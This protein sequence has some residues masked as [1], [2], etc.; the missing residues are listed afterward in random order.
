[1]KKLL[2]LLLSLTIVFSIAGCGKKNDKITDDKEQIKEEQLKDDVSS[3]ENKEEPKE[4]KKEEVIKTSTSD[5]SSETQNKKPDK[6]TTDSTVNNDKPVISQ[7]TG[8]KE[9]PTDKTPVENTNTKKFIENLKKSANLRW[10]ICVEAEEMIVGSSGNKVFFL[11]CNRSLEEEGSDKS[12]SDGN[13]LLKEFI[14]VAS[15][16]NT[17]EEIANAVIKSPVLPFQPMV[18]PVEPGLLNGFDNNEITG[19][20]DGVVFAPMIGSIPFIGYVFVL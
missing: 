6:N 1:M 9:E 3:N 17:A 4:E 14:K 18:M 8:K 5:K 15:S 2:A 10:N 19:F 16:L 20:K 7:D 13:A 12:E 11:M